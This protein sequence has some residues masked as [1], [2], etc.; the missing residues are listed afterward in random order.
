MNLQDAFNWLKLY[1]EQKK[2]KEEHPLLTVDGQPPIVDFKV[3]EF[4]PPIGMWG[5]GLAD[6][7]TH[8]DAVDSIRWATVY[9]ATSPDNIDNSISPNDLDEMVSCLGNEYPSRI[10]Y[11][12]QINR[13]VK[14]LNASKEPISSNVFVYELGIARVSGRI[15]ELRKRGYHIATIRKPSEKRAT[16]YYCMCHPQLEDQCKRNGWIIEFKN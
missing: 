2:K 7:L 11:P 3:G 16:S 13:I 10:V 9:D 14:E 8:D 5:K 6:D 4:T 15:F 1:K 12:S